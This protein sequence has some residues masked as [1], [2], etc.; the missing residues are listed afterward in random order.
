M[1]FWMLHYAYKFISLK[2]MLNLY[3][4]RTFVRSMRLNWFLREENEVG[5]QRDEE[6]YLKRSFLLDCGRAYMILAY[7]KVVV[8]EFKLQ[9]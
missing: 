9:E 1:G 3:V 4:A 7:R 6:E 5:D 8:L 2:I